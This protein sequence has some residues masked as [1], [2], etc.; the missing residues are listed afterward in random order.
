MKNEGI[1]LEMSKNFKELKHNHIQ[2]RLNA[3]KGKDMVARPTYG[4]IR[5]IR[6]ALAMSS[7][8]LAKKLEISAASMSETEKSEQNEGITIKRL[9]RVADAMNCDLVYYLLP[10]GDIS[11]MI[12]ERAR[13]LAQEK[14]LA[15][16][17]NMELEDQAVSEKFIQEVV[18]KEVQRLK[19]S[20]KLWDD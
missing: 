1:I 17:Y 10:R 5:F 6:E 16:R 9:R 8:A 11:E 4:W 20:K 7:K 18:E 2:L 12:E 13:H 19:E 15:M 14:V 3:L